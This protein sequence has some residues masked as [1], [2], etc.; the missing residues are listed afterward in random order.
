MVSSSTGKGLSLHENLLMRN[1][2]QWNRLH[3]HKVWVYRSANDHEWQFFRGQSRSRS[4]MVVVVVEAEGRA[5]SPGI[6][7]LM[8]EK[9]IIRLKISISKYQHVERVNNY[10][11][12]IFTYVSLVHSPNRCK[13]RMQQEERQH[14]LQRF[15]QIL[16]RL[17]RQ[18]WA[19]LIQQFHAQLR[20]IFLRGCSSIPF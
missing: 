6:V 16:R 10:F 3:I 18:F 19:I 13:T 12:Y 5:S 8:L 20:I 7:G 11:Y 17:V 4:P 2:F 14:Q 1:R 15:P 9:G